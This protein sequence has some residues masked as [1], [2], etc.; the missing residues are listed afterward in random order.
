MTRNP[1]WPAPA[2][3]WPW[4]P[5]QPPADEVTPDGYRIVQPYPDPLPVVRGIQC[6]KCGARFDA[7]KAYAFSCPQT[8]CP[9]F[10]QVTC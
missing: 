10:P 9:V 7:D 1:Y 6:G 4:A 8:G 3:T 2:P 5:A